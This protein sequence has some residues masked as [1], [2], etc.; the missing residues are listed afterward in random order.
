MTALPAYIDPETYAA[1][2]EMRQA[3]KGIPFTPRAQLLIIKKAM[4]FHGD[5]Y[6]PN[7]ALEKSTIQ[8]WRDIYPG[9][10]IATKRDEKDKAL[11]K[12]E[13]DNLRATKPDEQ[14]RQRIAELTGRAKS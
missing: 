3:L 8:G 10:K 12:I 11:I 14:T 9:E 5:G 1:F 4:R 7:S 6:C 13:A 2:L